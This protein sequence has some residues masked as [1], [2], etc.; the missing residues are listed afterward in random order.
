M[1]S[2]DKSFAEARKE[3]MM[4]AKS[5][6]SAQ[7]AAEASRLAA[8]CIAGYYRGLIEGGMPDALAENMT[9]DFAVTIH[10]MIKLG[11][12]A[13]ISVMKVNP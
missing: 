3:A 9:Q 5:Q 6:S 11:G 7:E 10:Q 2:H 1:N 8:L 13:A 4:N 12:E